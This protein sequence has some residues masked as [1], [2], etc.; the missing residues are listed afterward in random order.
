[1][2][3]SILGTGSYG[4]ALASRFKN[5]DIKMWT[6]F[7]EEKDMLI[8]YRGND[9]LLPSI[10]L[11]DRVE[12]TT[13]IEY[14]T[15]DSDVI[16]IAIPIE[17]ISDTLRLLSK[18][19]TNQTIIV[20]TKGIE[21]DSCMF[22]YELIQ[23]Y[24]STD[25][26][27]IISGPT[28]SLDLANNDPVGFVVATKYKGIIKN[29]NDLFNN[30]NVDLIYSDDIVG[31]EICGTIK[32]IIAIG[33]GVLYGMGY[34]T[35]TVAS[36][37][38]KAINDTKKIITNLGG[39]SET[40]LSYAGIGD[41]ILTCTSNKSRN[42]SLGKII[43]ENKNE[44]IIKEYISNNTIEGLY[45]LKGINKLL[46][47]KNIKSELIEAMYELIINKNNKIFLKYIGNVK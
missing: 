42:F 22:T 7:E 5:N 4:L 9:K 27:G 46:N 43:G 3:V 47:N 29:V 18:Y 23:K 8:K 19:Y 33:S 30:D 36:Y 45:S 15:C 12:I 11:D 38:T 31:T 35:S 20:A 13:N 28:F 34:N 14:C 16:V 17:Y 24:L 10:R 21:N 44:E 37:L 32:N 6:K 25:N 26:I 40:I 39:S 1:M 2:K 41:I